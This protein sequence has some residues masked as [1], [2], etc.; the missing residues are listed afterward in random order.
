MVTVGG[1]ADQLGREMK[2]RKKKRQTT[3]KILESFIV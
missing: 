3:L 1:V 2:N